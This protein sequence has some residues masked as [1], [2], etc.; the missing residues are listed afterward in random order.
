MAAKKAPES[1]PD[2]NALARAAGLGKAVKQFPQD[3]ALAAQAAENAR[4][5]MPGLDDAAAEPW[6]PMRV[7]SVP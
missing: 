4:S 6:P 1:T 5:A 3:I 2:A 7:R